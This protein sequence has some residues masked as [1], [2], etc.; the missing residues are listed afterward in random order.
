MG[1]AKRRK[2]R[3]ASGQLKTFLTRWVNEGFFNEPKTLAK[4]VERYHEHGVI[5]RQ[6]SLSG[7][8]LEAVREGLLARAK[9]EDGGKQVWGYRARSR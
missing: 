5:T 7:L 8:V 3:T 9:I 4:L 2:S 6:T 1:D